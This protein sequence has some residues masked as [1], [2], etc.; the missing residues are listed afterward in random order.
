MYQSESGIPILT[1]N[2]SLGTLHVETGFETGLL[3][4]QLHTNIIF[5]RYKLKEAYTLWL[6]LTHVSKNLSIVLT[7][8]DSYLASSLS[9]SSSP[10]N[11]SHKPR[12]QNFPH[13]YMYLNQW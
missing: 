2:A 6:P 12:Q 3:I 11:I 13:M 1:H 8:S 9:Q 5:T 10:W 4:K 7:H